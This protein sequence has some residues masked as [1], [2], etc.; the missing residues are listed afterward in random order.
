MAG[1]TSTIVKLA[2]DDC[3]EELQQELNNAKLFLVQRAIR[4]ARR[5]GILP[6]V[7]A[8]TA[9]A[10]K[11]EGTTVTLKVPKTTQIMFKIERSPE[12]DIRFFDAICDFAKSR[13][14]KLITASNYASYYGFN[15]KSRGMKFL[16]DVAKQIKTYD[17]C[18]G[19]TVT[20]DKDA[21][22]QELAT[23]K[24]VGKK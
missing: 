18:K 19:I 15:E 13:R 1:L 21:V 14:G 12:V 8:L 11:M 7:V 24:K 23:S 17:N 5:K 9:L 3:M 10:K 4:V 20:I 22:G 16:T 2:G 6:A